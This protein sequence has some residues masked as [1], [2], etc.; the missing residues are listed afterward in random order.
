MEQITTPLFVNDGDV[1]ESTQGP[2]LGTSANV[3]CSLDG[4]LVLTFRG[5]P[6]KDELLTPV[7]NLL[8][9]LGIRR[10]RSSG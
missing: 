1:V 2:G 9:T 8:K 3:R 4:N 6:S 7:T 5:E 10:M